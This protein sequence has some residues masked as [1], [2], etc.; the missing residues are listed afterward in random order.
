M[1]IVTL[2]LR[3][4]RILKFKPDGTNK[5]MVKCRGYNLTKVQVYRTF[6]ATHQLARPNVRLYSWQESSQASC[7]NM[8][9][10]NK[11]QFEQLRIAQHLIRWS[12]LVLPVSVAVGALVAL[13]L[14][15]LESAT[16]IRQ[17]NL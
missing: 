13:F 12:L 1:G 3:C 4:F 16:H 14:W 6:D 15:L 7:I 10:L 2:L 11:Y 5:D 17:A 8:F 9:A